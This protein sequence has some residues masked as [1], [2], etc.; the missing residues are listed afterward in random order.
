MSP[1]YRPVKD[2]NILKN[3]AKNPISVNFHTLTLTQK[4]HPAAGNKVKGTEFT[5][6]NAGRTH[7]TK[8]QEFNYTLLPVTQGQFSL[9]HIGPIFVNSFISRGITSD[10]SRHEENL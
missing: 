1:F 6:E 2:F 8:N 7:R 10:L 5:V 4:S 9:I 3:Q